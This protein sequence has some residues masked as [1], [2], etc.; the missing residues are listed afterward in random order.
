MWT[1]DMK[2]HPDF[3]E[4]FHRAFAAALKTAEAAYAEARRRG[5]SLRGDCRCA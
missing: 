1:A 4:L 3:G 5:S 2:D